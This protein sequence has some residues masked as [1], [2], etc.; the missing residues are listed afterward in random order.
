M[1]DAEKLESHYET[2]ARNFYARTDPL[3]DEQQVHALMELLRDHCEFG[4]D[5]ERA[6]CAWAVTR[7]AAKCPCEEMC[8]K[9]DMTI[10]A[11][12]LI[13]ERGE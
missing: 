2:I 11:V 8:E 9:C 4:E 6:A 12:D 13:R 1:T 3:S 5:R 7:F 10:K